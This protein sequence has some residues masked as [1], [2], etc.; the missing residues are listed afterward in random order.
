MNSDL[1][2]LLLQ[3]M[4]GGGPEPGDSGHVPSLQD[5]L[6]QL[7]ESDPRAALLAKFLAR[8]DAREEPDA[9]EG[10]EPPAA[11]ADAAP[12]TSGVIDEDQAGDTGG[13]LG[14]H[15]GPGSERLQRVIKAMYA[16]LE[17]L[18][19][20]N[21]G[22]ASAFGSCYLCWGADPSCPVCQGA[23]RPGFYRPDEVLLKQL[24]APAL[25]RLR[26]DGA[27][28]ATLPP[29]AARRDRPLEPSATEGAP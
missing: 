11:S 15:G 12:G 18:R 6:S 8:R 24:V 10:G 29:A 5:L 3:R 26:A 7:G 22:L 23:G 14:V 19:E 4:S 25:R 9:V 2:S 28:V 1:Y 20:C 16:E 13:A 27:R 21:D 17:H